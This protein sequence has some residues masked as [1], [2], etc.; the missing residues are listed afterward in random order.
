MVFLCQN[1]LNMYTAK[2]VTFSPQNCPIKTRTTLVLPV[3]NEQ[4][5]IYVFRSQHPK[6][7]L[8]F[9]TLCMWIL[10]HELFFQSDIFSI[11][12]LFVLCVF[13]NYIYFLFINFSK[14]LKFFRRLFHPIFRQNFI[15][16]IY[17]F[18]LY[19]L[20]L[21]LNFSFS[22]LLT[23]YLFLLYFMAHFY[24]GMYVFTSSLPTCFNQNN[25]F[26]LCFICK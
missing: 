13:M 12:I 17:N 19:F 3:V 11:F 9:M 23:F 26:N 5:A 21:F 25:F 7:K 10:F 1:L 14:K 4:R 6:K 22:F 8:S 24:C 15:C 16:I 18:F 20:I 2:N